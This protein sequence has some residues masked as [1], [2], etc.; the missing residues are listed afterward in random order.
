MIKDIKLGVYA[1][2]AF[3]GQTVLENFSFSAAMPT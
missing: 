3:G 2:D 1:C